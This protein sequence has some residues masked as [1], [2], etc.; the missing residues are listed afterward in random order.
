MRLI[1]LR[2]FS[3]SYAYTKNSIS[4]IEILSFIASLT[5]RYIRKFEETLTGIVYAIVLDGFDM[6]KEDH[7]GLSSFHAMVLYM[8]FFCWMDPHAF[9]V[10]Q[11]LSKDLSNVR[12]VQNKRGSHFY[13]IVLR[14]RLIFRVYFWTCTIPK[15]LIVRNAWECIIYRFDICSCFTTDVSSVVCRLQTFLLTIWIRIGLV[16]CMKGL[17]GACEANWES[18]NF[19]TWPRKYERMHLNYM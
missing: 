3:F 8:L 18:W 19:S 2:E 10:L 17:P 1:V 9:L 12:Q 13:W 15:I 4:C 14:V 7:L 5:H 6:L 11:T 16:I